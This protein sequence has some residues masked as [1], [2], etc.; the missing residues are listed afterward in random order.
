MPVYDDSKKPGEQQN[1]SY[2]QRSAMGGDVIGRAWTYW[3]DSRKVEV[4]ANPGDDSAYF[5]LLSG[6]GVRQVQGAMPAESKGVA[7]T[8]FTQG[9]TGSN[10][11][12]NKQMLPDVKQEEISYTPI[13]GKTIASAGQTG[14]N[15]TTG[16]DEYA[17]EGE[18]LITYTDGTVERRKNGGTPGQATAIGEFGR[19]ADELGITRNTEIKGGAGDEITRAPMSAKQALAAA[20]TPEEADKIIQGEG[21]VSTK[22]LQLVGKNYRG[23]TASEGNTFYVDPKTKEILERPESL[24]GLAQPLTVAGVAGT[25]IDVVDKFKAVFGRDPSA[26]ELKYW[27]GRT[28]KAGSALIGA[29]QFAKQSGGAVGK[30]DAVATVDPVQNIKNQ[31]NEGQAKL[32]KSLTESGITG[33][34]SDSKA[35]RA[36]IDA[37]VPETK[38]ATEFTKEQLSSSQFQ[39]SQN[40]L[41]QAKNALRQLDTDY[42]ANLVAAERTP[43]L[44]MGAIRRNQGEL[45]ISYN[46]ARAQL[47]TEVQMYSDIVASKTAIVGMFMNAFKF[48]QQ[49][50]QQSYTNQFNKAVQMYNMTRQEEQDEFNMTQKLQDNQRANLSVITSMIQSGNMKYDQLSTEQKSQIMSMEQAVGLPA[51]FSS[52]VGQAVKDPVVSFGTAYTDAK[53]VRRQPVYTTNPTTGAFTTK[54]IVMEGR[55]K[56]AGSGGTKPTEKELAQ[57]AQATVASQLNERKGEDGYISPNDYRTA[58][59]AWITA[60]YSGKDFNDSFQYYANP[61]H[62]S[63]YG[64]KEE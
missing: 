42:R 37:K 48:D 44:S 43:G 34:S 16:V 40:D 55:E 19:T 53:G 12:G 39:E 56:V 29:M 60:G 7:S 59:S 27:Q 54:E 13:E 15:P 45:D 31:A 64:I 6:G 33:N 63:E 17:N 49:A 62:L 35:L 57:H 1:K 36:F 25:K 61:A 20:K 9:Y 30:T 8:L 50:A 21:Q 24:Q 2:A 47:A 3:D 52:F 46:R 51:G 22:D 58:Q 18:T 32:A 11:G 41:N 14:K 10:E 28:D 4:Y 23:K 5:E 38:S 26:E